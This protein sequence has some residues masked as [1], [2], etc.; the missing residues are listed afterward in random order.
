M[1]AGTQGR[2]A[3]CIDG[4]DH[5]NGFMCRNAY[6]ITS[7]GTPS[8]MPYMTYTQDVRDGSSHTFSMARRFRSFAPGRSGIGSTARRPPAPSR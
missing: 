8:N 6:T 7:A 4:L 1:S 3:Y 2:N 5:G